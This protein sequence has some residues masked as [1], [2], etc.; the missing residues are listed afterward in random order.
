MPGQQ[1]QTDPDTLRSAGQSFGEIGKDFTSAAKQLKSTLDGLGE[2]W[3]GDSF[4]EAFA[5][6]YQP[7]KEGFDQSM[8][9]LGDELSHMGTSLQTMAANYRSSDDDADTSIH[10]LAA[11]RP[12]LSL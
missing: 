3:G 12:N 2:F 9:F 11:Q 4:G 1:F 10:T 7:V 8:P 6:V 5:I